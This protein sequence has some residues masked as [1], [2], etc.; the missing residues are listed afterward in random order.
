[1]MVILL[2]YH[3]ATTVILYMIVLKIYCHLFV[4]TAFIILARKIDTKAMCI[5]S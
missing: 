5:L 1:M 2:L 3:T 4:S